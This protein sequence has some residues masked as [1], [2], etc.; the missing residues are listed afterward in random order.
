VVSTNFQEISI[1][2]EPQNIPVTFSTYPFVW[3]L[4]LILWAS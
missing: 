2:Y 4:I 3:C 1:I